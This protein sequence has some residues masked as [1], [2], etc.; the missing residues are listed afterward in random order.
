MRIPAS[1]PCRRFPSHRSCKRPWR[2]VVRRSTAYAVALAGTLDH[3]ATLAIAEVVRR[4]DVEPVLDSLDLTEIVLQRVDLDA[5]VR[6]VITHVDE[7]EI[8]TV[9]AKVDVNAIAG[10]LDIDR[11][12]DQMD[13]TAIVLSRVDLVKVVD[14][15]LDRMDLTAIVLS[16]VDLVKVVDAVLDQMDLIALANEI[17]EGVDLPGDHP[18]LDRLDGLRDREGRA[19]AG[20]RRRPGGRPCHRPAPAASQPHLRPRG[21][22]RRDG[23]RGGHRRGTRRI[24]PVPREARPFQGQRAGLVTR[25]IAAVLDIARR[26]RR[27]ARRLPRPGG[28]ALPRQPPL[29]PVPRAGAGLQPRRSVRRGCRLPDG[30]LD[31]QRPHVRLPRHGV[32]GAR[33]RWSPAPVGRVLRPRRV[34][35]GGADRDRVGA[36]QPQQQ[37][38]P[39]PR[40]RHAGGLRLGT[41]H[42]PRRTLPGRRGRRRRR[43][44]RRRQSV[45]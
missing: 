43:R 11:L 24:S 20:H 4:V 40:P 32:A 13:L 36:H 25:L 9:V 15:V 30:V 2:P 23:R 8:A 21:L 1:T 34:R 27:P 42:R 16:R 39:G 12:L 35:R 29:V 10:T 26:R 18:R 19:D 31:P 38:A 7:D 41:A 14:A 33:A 37:V 17:I 6:T 22:L 5:V 3:L 45:S 44:R 28:A